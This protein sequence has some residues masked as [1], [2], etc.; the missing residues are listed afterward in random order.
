[1]VQSTIAE[2]GRGNEAAMMFTF[3]S[4]VWGLTPRIGCFKKVVN[5]MRQ[6][7]QSVSIVPVT[8]MVMMTDA[9]PNDGYPH[10]VTGH[11]K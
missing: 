10:S 8:R 9:F 1:M 3:P 5:I 11:D 6:A 2:E 7:G 4:N